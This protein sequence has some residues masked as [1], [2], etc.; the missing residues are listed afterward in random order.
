MESFKEKKLVEDL[1]FSD[2]TNDSL[3][4]LHQKI[5]ILIARE[6]GSI[7]INRRKKKA[8]KRSAAWL[9]EYRQA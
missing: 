1:W 5:W 7:R 3:M 8:H 4:L 2:L 6:S 9:K